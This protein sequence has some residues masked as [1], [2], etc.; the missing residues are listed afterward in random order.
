MSEEQPHKDKMIQISLKNGDRPMGL[1]EAVAE[2]FKEF[3][4]NPHKAA[5]AMA[6]LMVAQRH[7]TGAEA[8]TE[9]FWAGIFYAKK[10]PDNVIIEEQEPP[11]YRDNT[12]SYVS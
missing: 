2:Y 12:S 11:T 10:H 6:S 5:E 3:Y 1:E 8:M 7:E 9:M 4:I